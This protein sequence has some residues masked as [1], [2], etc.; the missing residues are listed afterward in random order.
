MGT[1]S[2]KGHRSKMRTIIQ[3]PEQ[4]GGKNESRIYS[5]V[6]GNTWSRNSPAG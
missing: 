6:G 2:T 3:S 5:L 1:C 4:S